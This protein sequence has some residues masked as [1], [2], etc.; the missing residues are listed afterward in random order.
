MKLI[1]VSGERDLWKVVVCYHC[2]QQD[3][4]TD[5]IGSE[6]YIVLVAISERCAA[7]AAGDLRVNIVED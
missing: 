7:R 1:L 3:S 5:R 4:P 6:L 2:D